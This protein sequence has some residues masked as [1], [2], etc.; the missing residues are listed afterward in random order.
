MLGCPRRRTPWHAS[1]W[2]ST[3]SEA[4]H[5]ALVWALDEGRLR[6]ATVQVVHAWH[7]PYVGDFGYAGAAIDL[8]ALEQAANDV[9]DTALA[10][11]DTDGLPAAVERVVVS[12]NAA[13]AILDVAQGADLV[14]VGSRG[15]GGFSGLLL[16]S[17][18]HQVAH[19]ASCPVVVVP[20]PRSGSG[21]AAPS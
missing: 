18:S 6:Q 3:G 15:R 10:S 21:A 1:L 11:A 16:G 9:V 5:D 20:P 2:G 4:A 17:V 14:V 8:A 13:A 19:H 12:G 7:A